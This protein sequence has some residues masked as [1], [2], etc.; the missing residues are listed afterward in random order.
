[1]SNF[2]GFDLQHLKRLLLHKKT[3]LNGKRFNAGMPRDAQ[4]D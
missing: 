4:P 2:D 3:F 1:M